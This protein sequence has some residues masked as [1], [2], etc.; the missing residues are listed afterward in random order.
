[1]YYTFSQNNS[2]GSWI[3]PQY[4]IVKADSASEANEIAENYGIY[5][6]GVK[7]EIDC[8]CCGDRWCQ[9]WEDEGT[10]EPT[11]FGDSN[12]ADYDYELYE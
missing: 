5:F 12:L 3:G 6:D 4:V 1:M 9:V 8:E 11:I 7:Q 10:E 2:G